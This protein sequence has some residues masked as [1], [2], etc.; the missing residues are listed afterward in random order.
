MTRSQSAPR[1]C[2]KC[3]GVARWTGAI[4]GKFYPPVEFKTYRC[5]ACGKEFHVPRGKAGHR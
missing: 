4:V 1:K 2:P 5:E 3:G